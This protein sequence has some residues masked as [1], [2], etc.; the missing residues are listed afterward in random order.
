MI[1]REFLKD[2]LKIPRIPSEEEIQTLVSE[3]TIPP[4]AAMEFLLVADGTKP[5]FYHSPSYTVRKGEDTVDEL[6]SNATSFRMAIDTFQLYG[7][8]NS[9]I[10]ERG[11]YATHSLK[12]FASS[13]QETINK[14][15]MF[16]RINDF[17]NIGLTLG[18]PETAIAAFIRGSSFTFSRFDLEDELDDTIL[19]SFLT[20]H[21]SKDYWQEEIEVVKKWRDKTEELSPYLFNLVTNKW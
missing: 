7:K 20:F 13:S 18:Y 6:E 14:L 11:E 17:G 16:D 19:P 15:E 3:S 4:S 1:E 10:E 2:G 12:V 5:A 21:L 9:Y 8:V